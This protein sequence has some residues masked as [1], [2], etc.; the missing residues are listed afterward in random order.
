[1]EIPSM[2]RIFKL[3]YPAPLGER[4]GSRQSCI[5]LNRTLKFVGWL[6]PSEGSNRYIYL[7]WTCF[8]FASC[9]IYIPI[10][11]I[12]SF[13][14]GL[15]SFRLAELV[16]LLQISINVIGTSLK[17]IAILTLIPQFRQTE[18]KLDELD[19]TLRNDNDRLKIHKAVASCNFT[20]LSYGNMFT[21]YGL[22]ICIA[23]ISMGQL[24]W[25]VYNPLFDWR[26]G[27]LQFWMQTILEYIAIGMIITLTLIDDAYN[28]VFLMIFRAHIDIL[29]D[30]IRQ[31][32]TDNLKT[33]S[34]NYED[35][36]SCIGYYK[37][38]RE[39]VSNRLI[40]TN[41]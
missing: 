24:P 30:H 18:S 25:M 5:Y 4:V 36:V 33:A 31:L 7:S 12:L 32:R 35:L 19:Q 8:V 39:S 1:M 9:I 16:G 3:T 6:P 2:K 20:F 10:G 11:F 40:H 38:I 17:S 22:S 34:E 13:V 37:L 14:K 15:G 27:T 28:I 26:D 29:K 23:S 41:C 21:L